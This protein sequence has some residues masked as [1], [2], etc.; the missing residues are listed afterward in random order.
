MAIRAALGRSQPKEPKHAD[1]LIFIALFCLGAIAV[2]FLLTS[3]AQ[4]ASGLGTIITSPSRL[5]T[6]YMAVASTGAALLN[7]G[8]VT[9]LSLAMVASQRVSLSG[10]LIAALLTVFGFSLFGKNLFNSI[11]IA[12]GVW[13]YSRV[14]QRPFGHF[15]LPAMF[16]TCLGPAVSTLA[17]GGTLPLW[18]GIIAGYGLGIILGFVIP[19]LAAHFLTFHQGFNL[20]NIGFTAGIVGMAASV[21]L[22]LLGVYFPGTRYLSSGNNLQLAILVYAACLGILLAGIIHHKRTRHLHHQ[23][24]WRGY[25]AILRHS[26]RNLT[27]FVHLEGF[28]VTAINM[29]VMG[30][31]V[32]TIVLAFGGQLN[33][34]ILGGIFCVMGFSAMGK[35]PVNATPVMAGVMLAALVGGSPTSETTVLMAALFGTTIAPISGF[36][37]PLF[38]VAAGFLHEALVHNISFLHSGMN[39]YNN[40]FSGGFVAA[41]LVPIFDVIKNFVKDFRDRRAGS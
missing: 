1:A 20:Y 8:L 41:I 40:G 32:T 16:G 38:G 12:L 10:P 19:P 37:G 6:D 33:G 17:F 13:L 29:G 3:P 7:A 21:V 30:S 24:T 4:L 28:G 5:L 18:L 36:Y 22:A 39:L 2:S 11:P 14:A 23:S 9:L 15:L 26:G 31:L 25:L 34:P 27:D 35:H